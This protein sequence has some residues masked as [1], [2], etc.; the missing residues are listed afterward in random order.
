M[1]LVRQNPSA[2]RLKIAQ[3]AP[4][5]VRVP[6]K[7]YGGTER[8]VHALTEELVRRGHDVT[9]FAAGTSITAAKLM[10]ASP[11]PL[12]EM[13]IVEPNAYPVLQVEEV[14]RQSARFDVIH[15]H[16]DDLPWLAGERIRAPLV[17]TLHGRLDL[18]E[19]R[20]LFRRYPRQPLVSISH[21]QRRPLADLELNWLATVHHGLPLATTYRL[22]DGGGG[23]LA[24]IGRIAPEKGPDAA[25][26]VAIRA[27]TRIK[28]A[29]RVGDRERA[30][31]R[32]KVAPLLEHPLVD[33]LGEIDEKEKGELLAEAKALLVPITWDEPF[34]LSFIEALAAGTP[35]ITRERGSLPELMRDGEHGFFA[36]SEDDLVAACLRVDEIDRT[37]CRRWALERFS[38]GTMA[39]GYEAVYRML[40]EE[41][42][43]PA[44]KRTPEAIGSVSS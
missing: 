42:A 37:A 24:F 27:G 35:V 44:A 15:S 38:A 3:V 26:R 12:W 16:V 8:V 6:P 10:A 11:L 13:G 2:K 22:G 18:P 20:A 43:Q 30:Y 36:E 17:T 28:V 34:G 41:L 9:L 7:T 32:D 29:A 1:N 40:I 14:V 39:D 4:L 19:V 23:Y 21:A 31:Y 25:I 33:W 5:A